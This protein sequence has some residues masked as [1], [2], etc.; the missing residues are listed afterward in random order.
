[1]KIVEGDCFCPSPKL[2]DDASKIV[3]SGGLVVAPTD[4]LYG[5]I[6]D[7]FNEKAYRRVYKVKGRS[8]GKPLPLLLGESHH[9]TILVQVDSLFWRLA[10]AFW[11]GPLTIVAPAAP[12]VP[13]YLAPEGKVGVRLP[14]CP[15]V[16]LIARRVGGA[17]TGTSANKSGRENPVTVYNAS[18]QLGDAVD[19][20]IDGGPT[21]LGKPST[22][23]EIVE[24]KVEVLREGAIPASRIKEVLGY[25]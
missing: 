20:Y 22:V 1:M 11:P 9:A 4:T 5:I 12:G 24:G 21:L 13:D 8:F 10:R 15:L 16:R 17:V 6:A 3:A 23:V 25:K 7:P 18:E 19:L 14:D 2:V